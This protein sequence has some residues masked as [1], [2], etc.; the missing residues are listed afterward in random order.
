M[1]N[2]GEA[3]K[4]AGQVLKRVEADGEKASSVAWRCG[5]A[6]GEGQSPRRNEAAGVKLSPCGLECGKQSI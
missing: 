2:M 6:A 5:G 4:T 1:T 3:E